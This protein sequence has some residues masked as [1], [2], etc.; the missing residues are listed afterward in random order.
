MSRVGKKPIDIPQGVTLAI[1]NRTVKAK[2]P[3]GELSV[4][5]MEGID[6]KQEENVLNVVTLCDEEQYHEYAA[7]HG[8]MR[9]LIQNIV[10]G[11]STGFVK[12]LEIQGVGYR[13]MQ[14]GND[15]KLQVG[16]SHD[17]IFPAPEGI[18][19]EVPEPT[20]IKVK[21]INKHQVGQVSANIRE[22][23]PPEPYKGKGIRY[24]GEYVRRKAGKAGK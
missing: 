15:L 19:F 9:A 24:K 23:R 1:E 14:Q 17:V 10:T 16:F 4:E 7:Y 5:L 22:V 6:V 13:A 18:T 2:G 21:G 12:E 3:L 20:S 11:V 8:L